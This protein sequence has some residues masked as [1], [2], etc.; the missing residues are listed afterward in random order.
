MTYMRLGIANSTSTYK[1]DREVILVL[2]WS[3]ILILGQ[4][5]Y[6]TVPPVDREMLSSILGTIEDFNSL[7]KSYTLKS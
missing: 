1:K 4:L 6:N 3:Q 2:V 7:A 5:K